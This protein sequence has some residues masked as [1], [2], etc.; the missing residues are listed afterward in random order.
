MMKINPGKGYEWIHPQELPRIDDEFVP[1]AN[2]YRRRIEK[3][4]GWNVTFKTRGLARYAANQAKRSGWCKD[5]ILKGPHR[6]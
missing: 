5:A 1:K 2:N 3:P 6:A 4:T